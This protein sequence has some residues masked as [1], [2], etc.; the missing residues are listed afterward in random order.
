MRKQ[1]IENAA[2][3]VA[4]QVRAVEDSID[5]V[6]ADIAELQSRMIRARSVTGVGVSTSQE[7]FAQL[8]TALQALVGARGSI[9]GCHAALA[10]TKQFIPGLRTVAWG[11][12]E[13]CPPDEGFA[14]LRVVA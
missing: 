9:A 13:E 12:G 5:G 14:N 7:A 2:F 11:D 8:A 3:E 6:L 4:T 10:H 1:Q